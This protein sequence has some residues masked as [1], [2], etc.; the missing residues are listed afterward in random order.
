MDISVSKKYLL[1]SIFL[2]ALFIRTALLFYTHHDYWGSGGMVLPQGEMARNIVNGKWFVF[3]KAQMKIMGDAQNKQLRLIDVSD[4]KKPTVERYTPFIN[5]MPGSAALLALTWKIFGQQKYIYLQIIQGI[6]DALMVFLIFWIGREIFNEKIGLISAFLFALFLPEA[7]LSVS[8]LRDV[9]ASFAAFGSVGLLIKYY[10]EKNIIYVILIG[11]IIGFSVYIRPNILFLPLFLALALIFNVGLKKSISFLVIT[12]I[13]AVLI[14]TPWIIRNYR[15]YHRLIP[16]RVGFWQTI[17]EG[18]GEFPNKFGAVLN[19]ETTYLNIRKEGYKV[20][21]GTPEYD[22]VIKPKVINVIKNYPFWFT[23]VILRRIPKATVFS[24]NDWGFD[25][26]DYSYAR[27]RK[28]TGGNLFDYFKEYPFLFFYKGSIRVIEGLIPIIALAG[29]WI[30]REKW[31]KNLLI[32]II[33]VYF[34]AAYIPLHVEPRYIL[35]GTISYLFFISITI[36]YAYE[37]FYLRNRVQ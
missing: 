14:L 13:L 30:E 7:R 36:N 32:A 6:M 4:F 15:I 3:N 11:L 21:Y 33:P 24:H 29:F 22:D 19:D 8:A 12:Q 16:T 25:K 28:K 35:P 34:I 2:I 27:F 20:E 9:W 18:F 5:D 1:V 17:W 31:R 23:G 37:R 10:K 26:D